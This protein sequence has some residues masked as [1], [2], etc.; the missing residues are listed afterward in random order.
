MPRYS[1]IYP[2]VIS[3]TDLKQNN[4][5]LSVLTIRNGRSLKQQ[6]QQH[7]PDTIK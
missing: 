2:K 5:P 3:R 4:A 6:V 1:K 7:R